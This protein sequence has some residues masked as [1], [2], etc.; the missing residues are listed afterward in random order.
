MKIYNTDEGYVT[1]E[2]LMREF[3]RVMSL[4]KEYEICKSALTLSTIEVN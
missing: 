1:E 4:E 2:H 3:I